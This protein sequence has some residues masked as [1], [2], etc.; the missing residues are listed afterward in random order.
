[1]GE[2]ERKEVQKQENLTRDLL[3]KDHNINSI[4]LWFSDGLSTGL[5]DPWIDFVQSLQRVSINSQVFE[6]LF[7]DHI[8]Y[9]NP[10]IVTSLTETGV[11]IIWCS[12]HTRI[13]S[14]YQLRPIKLEHKRMIP[15]KSTANRF[16]LNRTSGS[17]G[18]ALDPPN[19]PHRVLSVH[20]LL[21][22]QGSRWG[23]GRKRGPCPPSTDSKILSIKVDTHSVPH[24]ARD[25]NNSHCSSSWCYL[26]E[27]L[28]HGEGFC[29]VFQKCYCDMGKAFALVLLEIFVSL[30]I[31]QI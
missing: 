30:S 23:G 26:E 6:W 10:K 14:S 2:K 11:Q 13:R 7:F 22:S 21:E 17:T 31:F 16:R 28:C 25:D 4:I 5:R 19:V 8:N 1:M 15:L 12:P 20:A 24:P 9:G 18:S 29:T 27:L 3:F